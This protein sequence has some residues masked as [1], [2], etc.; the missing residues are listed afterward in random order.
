MSRVHLRIRILL[1]CGCHVDI[2]EVQATPSVEVVDP[3]PSCSGHY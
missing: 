2:Y 3:L 1:L